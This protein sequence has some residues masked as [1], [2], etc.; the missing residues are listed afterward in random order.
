MNQTNSQQHRHTH[1][2]NRYT[3][4][5]ASSLN[6]QQLQISTY[7]L[8]QMQPGVRCSNAA[9][10]RDPTFRNSHS[11]SLLLLLLR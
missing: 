1:K 7:M 4:Y 6:R 5:T 2:H 8:T 11:N 3:R 9:R 10:S